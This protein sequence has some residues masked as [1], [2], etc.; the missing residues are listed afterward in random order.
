[1][2]VTT[3]ACFLQYHSMSKILPSTYKSI[4]EMVHDIVEEYVANFDKTNMEFQYDLK[5]TLNKEGGH[6]QSQQP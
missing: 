1:M 6:T 2:A 5:R 4:D 3:V